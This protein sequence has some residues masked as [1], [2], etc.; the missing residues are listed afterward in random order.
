MLKQWSQSAGNQLYNILL[1]IVGTS[2][3][4]RNGFI[5]YSLPLDRLVCRTTLF[6]S[7]EDENTKKI[8]V[9][10][11]T[12][13]KPINDDLSHYLAG[14]IEGDGHFSK[15]QQL[16]IV[17][18]SLDI[19]LAYFIKSVLGYGTVRQVKN[20]NAVLFLISSKAGI[21]TVLNLIN[22]KIKTQVKL[23]QIISNILPFFNISFNLSLNTCFNNS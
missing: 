21:I 2:E 1:Y 17:F 19:H 4:L 13:L 8:S 7:L 12:H 20:K 3:T 15:Q 9:H 10:V 14:L 6:S 5:Y 16:V 22:G 11:P 23:D 18:N